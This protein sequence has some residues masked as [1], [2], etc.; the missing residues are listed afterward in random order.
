MKH[1]DQIMGEMNVELVQKGLRVKYV[2]TEQD[3][4]ECR[5]LGEEVAKR[6]TQTIL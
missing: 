2:P 4:A 5:A 3:L 6:I 1:L